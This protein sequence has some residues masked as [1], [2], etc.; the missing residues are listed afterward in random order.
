MGSGSVTLSGSSESCES[1]ECPD[2]PGGGTLP[3][4]LSELREEDFDGL[5]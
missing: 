3:Y 4:D 5:G 1:E 2:M